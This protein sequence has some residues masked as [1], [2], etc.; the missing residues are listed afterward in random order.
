MENTVKTQF[1]F[2]KKVNP[3]LPMTIDGEFVELEINTATGNILEAYSIAE[4]VQM[5]KDDNKDRVL[6]LTEFTKIS[7]VIFGVTAYN[8]YLQYLDLDDFVD[9]MMHTITTYVNPIA[10]QINKKQTTKFEESN[11]K[12]P[13]EVK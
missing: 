11:Y 3:K 8:D 9:L 12:K 13:F 2:N 5:N 7:K 10:E 6:F 4:K 1:E